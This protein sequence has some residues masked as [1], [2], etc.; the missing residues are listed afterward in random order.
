M[1]E[2][3]PGRRRRGRESFWLLVISYG[4]EGRE[5]SFGVRW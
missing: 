5:E 2:L 3:M 4:K 1:G